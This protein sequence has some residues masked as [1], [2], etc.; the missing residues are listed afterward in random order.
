MAVMARQNIRVMIPLILNRWDQ[1]IGVFL[2][3]FGALPESELG[4]LADIDTSISD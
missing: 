1:K 2:V 4:W 3:S